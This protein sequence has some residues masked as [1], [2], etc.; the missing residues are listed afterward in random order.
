MPTADFA[1]T[2]LFPL[3][4]IVVSAAE[5]SSLEIRRH[6]LRRH[7]LIYNWIQIGRG[8][9]IVAGA[10]GRMKFGVLHDNPD[11]AKTS[12]R[13]PKYW[14]AS[15]TACSNPA[16]W[17]PP[18]AIT[19]FKSFR[20]AKATSHLRA[21]RKRSEQNGGY[22]VAVRQ[23]RH[24]APCRTRLICLLQWR[25]TDRPVCCGWSNESRVEISM[26]YSVDQS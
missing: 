21:H 7:A 3:Y 6:L 23:V 11:P 8:L 1:T 13:P 16:P 20:P 12:Q 9:R 18:S 24:S 2:T 26:P 10:S 4:E 14:S 17:R 5:R 22:D 25:R 19:L 15:R